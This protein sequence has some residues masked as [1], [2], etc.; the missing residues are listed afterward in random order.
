MAII[1]KSILGKIS[2]KLGNMV[3]YERKGKVVIRSTSSKSNKA[4]SPKQLYHRKAF[5]IAQKFLTP[6][7]AELEMG[8]AKYKPTQSQGFARALSI[9]LKQGVVNEAGVPVLYPEKIMTSEGDLLGI[10]SASTEWKSGNV[11]EISWISNAFLGHAKESDRLFAI[12]YDPEGGRKWALIKGNYRKSQIQQIQF[13]WSGL[14]QGKFY[15]YLSFYSDKKGKLEYS[16][17][18]CLGRV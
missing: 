12:A 1:E 6:M 11:L 16:D 4:P 15:L 10:E 7:R 2:G 18:I 8:F 9:A 5:T 13:P 3:V 17:S 14:L